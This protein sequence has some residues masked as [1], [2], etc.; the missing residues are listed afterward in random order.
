MLQFRNC[1]KL[2]VAKVQVVSQ[3]HDSFF[4]LKILFIYLRE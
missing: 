3:G 1:A 4:C 2:Q